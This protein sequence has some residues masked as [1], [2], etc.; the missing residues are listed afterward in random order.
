M[1]VVY[2]IILASLRISLVTVPI[3]IAVAKWNHRK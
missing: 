2:F 1:D 3:A